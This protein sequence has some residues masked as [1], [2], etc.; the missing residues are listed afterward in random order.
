ME[1]IL[2]NPGLCYIGALIFQH[3]DNVS[4]AKCCQVCK[5]WHHFLDQSLLFYKRKLGQIKKY[6]LNKTWLKNNHVQWVDLIDQVLDSNDKAKMYQLS[7]LLENVKPFVR[8]RNDH[9]YTLT[10]LHIAVD[11]N[12]IF[13]V[14]FLTALMQDLKMNLLPKSESGMTPLHLSAKNGDIEIFKYLTQASQVI[15]PS[16]YSSLTPLHL[17]AKYGHL[18]IIQYMHPFIKNFNLQDVDGWTPLHY[19]VK[20]KVP[21]DFINFDF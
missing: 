21:F 18:A 17:A 13:S 11:K 9:L 5:L 16:S 3:L 19:A 12:D 8:A 10:P 6:H 20:H 2:A 15:N 14:Q 4:L 7:C 1:G